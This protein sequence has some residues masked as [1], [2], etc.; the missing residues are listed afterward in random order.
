MQIE[1][2]KKLSPGMRDK[3]DEVGFVYYLVLARMIDIDPRLGLSE[4]KVYV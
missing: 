4:G 1:E 2:G 3:L